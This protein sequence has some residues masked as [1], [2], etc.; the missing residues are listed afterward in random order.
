[1]GAVASIVPQGEGTERA[2]KSRMRQNTPESP[3]FSAFMVTVVSDESPCERNPACSRP[4]FRSSSN[5]FDIFVSNES[6]RERKPAYGRPYI[7]RIPW[8][9]RLFAYCR[10]RPLRNK[11]EAHEPTPGTPPPSRRRRRRTA[12]RRQCRISRTAPSRMRPTTRQDEN[13]TGRDGFSGG[14]SHGPKSH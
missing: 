9:F 6:P 3:S 8:N 7:N 14:E 13:G 4:C 12:M 5:I 1:M 10:I 2:D 11:G